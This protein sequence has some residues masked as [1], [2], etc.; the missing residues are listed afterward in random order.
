MARKTSIVTT[1]WDDGDPLDLRLAE[2]LAV[3]QL[4]G[5]F[6]VPL[7]YRNRPRL[8]NGQMRELAD[9][10]FEIGAHGVRHLDLRILDR[11]ELTF[12]LSIAKGV[13]E[14]TLG[15]PVDTLCY[16]CGKYDARV[17]REAQLAGYR[18]ARTTRML[19]WSTQFSGFEMPVTVQALPHVWSSYCR[20][21]LKRGSPQDLIRYIR[22]FANSSWVEIAKMTFDLV[23]EYGGVWHLYGHSWE[24]ERHALWQQLCEVLDYV[25]Y[26]STVLYLTNQQVLE[27]VSWPPTVS[28]AVA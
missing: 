1:S 5:T 13:L 18:G 14:Q 22:R 3:R 27:Q 16:P 20:N 15:R 6:Y 24:I 11:R 21:L 2:M 9:Q 8:S 4:P 12:E 7:N 28:A 26:K 19:C 25:S 23:Q 17:I 10:Q